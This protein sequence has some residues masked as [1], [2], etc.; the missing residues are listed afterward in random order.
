MRLLARNAECLF[1]LARYLERA[2][3]LA[4]VI[5]MQSTFGAQD[6]DQ[7]W[8][9]LLTLHSNE[10]LF[11]ERFEPSADTIVAFYL[12]DKGN[13]GSVRSS[14]HW[15]RENARAL[16]PFIPLEMWAQ[17]NTFQHTIELIGADD[18]ARSK[19]PRTCAQIRAGC[20]AQIGVAEGL[21]YRDEGYQ[22]F[23]LGLMIER[24]DQTSRLLDVKYAQG[25]MSRSSALSHDPALDFMFWSTIL[26]TV[27]AYQVFHRLMASSPDAETVA[28]FLVLNPSHPR[29][30][31]FCVREITDAL[32]MLRSGFRLPGANA[33]LEA[34]EILMQGLQVA[35]EDAQLLGRLHE[36]NDWVQRALMHLTAQIG[37]SFFQASP[38]FVQPEPLVP[39]L[40]APA[41]QKTRTQGQS[42]SQ[43]QT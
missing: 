9:W 8:N 17:L 40:S 18:I 20:L 15:A 12:T 30:I 16:R 10:A 37:G 24:A 31:G 39:P 32:N 38:P 25:A 14:I 4:R 28:R 6:K 5:E 13:A 34:C 7:G 11:R 23:K 43:G 41:P 22:F 26:R 33:G 2:A 42:Q 29:S 27:G 1:W 35:S 36:F 3:C 19:L 21:L